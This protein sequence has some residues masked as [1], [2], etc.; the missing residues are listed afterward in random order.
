MANEPTLGEL[1]RK[2]IE[3][4]RNGEKVNA[5]YYLTQ[6]LEKDANNETALMWMASVTDAINERRGYLQR[7]LDINPGNDRAREALRRIAAQTAPPPAASGESVFN[8]ANTPRRP[9]QDIRDY[10][11]RPRAVERRAGLN[12]YLIAALIVAL[13]VAAV[14]LIAVAANQPAETAVTTGDTLAL[15]FA[16]VTPPPRPT[17][18]PG[19]LPTATFFGII[20]TQDPNAQVLPPTFTP[21]PTPIPTETPTPTPTPLPLSAYRVVFSSLQPDDI[22]PSLFSA[23]A[24]GSQLNALNVEGGVGA[25]AIS[26]D[27]ARIVFVRGGE[28]AATAGEPQGEGAAS[29]E[30]DAEAAPPASETETPQLYLASLDRIDEAVQLTSLTGSSIVYPAWSPDG[31]RIVFASDQDGDYELFVV[32]ADGTGLTQITSNRALDTSPVFAPDGQSIVYASDF[33]SPGFTEIYL[34]AP[35][36]TT[37]RLTD[38]AGSSFAP[39]FSPDGRRIAFVSDRTGDADIYIMDA[40]GQRPFLLTIDDN[41][42]EDRMPTFSRDGRFIVFASNRGGETFNWYAIDLN[43]GNAIIPLSLGE[44]D[45]DM[46]GFLP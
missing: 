28:P 27:G 9:Q 20:V 45:A 1:L 38:D 6:A 23:R 43:A 29:E 10:V 37:T 21:T 25:F 2:G 24:D 14:V 22:Y 31:E 26:P 46:L 44:G 35:D 19:P 11:P 8:D 17:E 42:A 16:A 7:A 18:D 30:G 4:A 33:E 13:A 40:N 36:G 3:A 34:R 5:R 12:G 32:R 39:V 41:N 15:T